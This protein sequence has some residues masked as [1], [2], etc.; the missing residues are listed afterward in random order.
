MTASHLTLKYTGIHADWSC[1]CKTSQIINRPP[2][3]VYPWH[4]KE[5]GWQKEKEKDF[6]D[7]EN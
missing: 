1:G 7:I 6:K 5:Q 3:L 2:L 4:I